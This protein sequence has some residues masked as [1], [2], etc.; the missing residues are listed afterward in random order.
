MR[1]FH[2]KERKRGL[3]MIHQLKENQQ[4]KKK[5]NRKW[6][7]FLIVLNGLLW[8]TGIYL[9]YL[10]SDGPPGVSNG[11][12]TGPGSGNLAFSRDDALNDG[13][14]SLSI[15]S[16]HALLV[17][18]TTG[19]ILL[20]HHADAAAYP[21]SLTKMMTVLIAIESTGEEGVVVR[22]DFDALHHANAAMVGFEYGEL[23]TLSEVLHGAMLSSGAD[24]TETIAYHVSGSYEGFVT[25]MNQRAA[26]IGMTNTNFAN[27]SGLHHPDQHTTAY[28]MAVF[29]RYALENPVFREVFTARTYTISTVTGESRTLNSTM[30]SNLSDPVFSG[31]E[32]LGGKDGYTPQAG[33]CLASLATDGE[34]EFVLITLGG[35]SPQAHIT[36]AFAIY[37]YFLD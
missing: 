16:E 11:T 24:A 20:E 28:D 9:W 37:T 17:N 4:V 26:Q 32:I 8:G 21:A 7:S 13:N 18:L 30:F 36:D 31:G 5:S 19:E 33:V 29:L 15:E 25:R 10:G 3:V 1:D 23:R 27:A 2:F 22:A 12:T 6:L 34:H 14:T 35:R